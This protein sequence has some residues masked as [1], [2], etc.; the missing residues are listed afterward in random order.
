MNILYTNDF[1]NS[2]VLKNKT[3]QN[4]TKQN[5]QTNKQINQNKKNKTKH[6]QKQNNL[7][8]TF[9]LLLAKYIYI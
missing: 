9:L 3:K 2:A 4:K 1:N 7:Q 6:K 5:K 8:M